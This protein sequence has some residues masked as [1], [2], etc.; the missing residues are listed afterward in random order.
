MSL[1]SRTSRLSA[2]LIVA[3]ALSAGGIWAGAVLYKLFFPH[4]VATFQCSQQHD[5]VVWE[6]PGNNY[7]FSQIY[8]E[9]RRDGA[10]ITQRTPVGIRRYN[11]P[12][13]TYDYIVPADGQHVGLVEASARD[14]VIAMFDVAREKLWP[15][16]PIVNASNSAQVGEED[17]INI[18]TDSYP[19]LNLILIGD[20]PGDRRTILD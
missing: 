8:V 15:P 2:W 11:R 17:M 19:T 14:I 20:K 13:P 16:P 12:N 5:L 7:A 1:K 9:V 3:A 6:G 18:L 10:P 4:V